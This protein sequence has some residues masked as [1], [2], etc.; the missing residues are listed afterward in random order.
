MCDT[1]SRAARWAVGLYA[2]FK[3]ALLAQQQRCWPAS[4]HEN[5][6]GGRNRVTRRR[7]ARDDVNPARDRRCAEAV[8]G[9]RHTR[10]I[11]PA[12]APAIVGLHL[13]EPAGASPPNTNIRPSSTA[14]AMP[15]RAVGNRRS[16]LPAI[17]CGVIR[18]VR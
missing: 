13:V 9:R 16:L 6:I 10:V 11:A 8:S 5:L 17:G 12:V 4:R 14:A 15:L 1:P 7:P 18:L 3:I 2:R